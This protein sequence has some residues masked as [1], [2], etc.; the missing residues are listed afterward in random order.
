MW[1]SLITSNGMLVSRQ[2][3]HSSVQYLLWSN[4]LQFE[5]CYASSLLFAVLEG[6]GCG[7]ITFRTTSSW[8][9]YCILLLFRQ[10][11]VSLLVLYIYI[12]TDKTEI[13]PSLSHHL[14]VIWEKHLPFKRR[15]RTAKSAPLKQVL[16]I[17]TH[18][19]SFLTGF[20]GPFLFAWRFWAVRP[21]LPPTA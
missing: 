16:E 2:S 3:N 8:W 9:N 19:M 1:I 20:K 10:H 11:L 15:W 17:A 21:Q 6:N 4:H 5:S 14:C 7:T 12:H 18:L 13:L